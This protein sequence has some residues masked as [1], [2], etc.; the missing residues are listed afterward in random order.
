[1]AE[2]IIC[3]LLALFF[4]VMLIAGYVTTAVFLGDESV[5][6]YPSVLLLAIILCLV[7]HCVQLWKKLP[8]EEKK[9]SIAD[10]FRL[11]DRQTHI[12]LLTIV[13]TILYF[14]LLDTL[15]FVLLTPFICLY[16][17]I[18]L[19]ETSW[20]KGIVTS[21]LITAAVYCVFIYGLHIRLP[22]GTGI[23]RELTMKL[24]FLFG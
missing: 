8:S 17:I 5:R 1:M 24:E 15:S 12:F 7:L 21:I 11:K 2:F 9:R 19:G 14:L 10:I 6:L 18:M 22:R 13:V 3:G 20:L 16:Y 23:I 4:L